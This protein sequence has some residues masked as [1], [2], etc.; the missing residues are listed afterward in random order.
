[1]FRPSATLK[2]QL[3]HFLLTA[4]LTEALVTFCNPHNCSGVSRRERIAPSASTTACG[5]IHLSARPC[6]PIC[7]Q[8]AVFSQIIHCSLIDRSCAHVSPQ[9]YGKSILKATPIE[10]A[11]LDVLAKNMHMGS[12]ETFF[13][14][15]ILFLFFCS[16][17]HRIGT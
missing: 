9:E 3:T 16:G 11:T 2:G 7:L 6:T 12:L 15:F 14:L 17:F 4:L 5:V 8:T 13:C 10:E 1:M